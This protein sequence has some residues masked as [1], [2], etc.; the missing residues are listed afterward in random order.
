MNKLEKVVYD[1]VK[2]NPRIKFF[3]RNV[4]QSVLDIMPIP[5][6]YFNGSISIKENYFYGFHDLN[7]FSSSNDKVLANASSLNFKMP[8]DNDEL[9][10]GFFDLVDGKMKTFHQIGNTKAWN[11][12][13]GCRLQWIKNDIIF[14]DFSD[15][16]YISKVVN[17][18]G[19]LIKKF[20]FPIDSLSNNFNFA[21]SFSYERLEFLM[22]GY[23]YRFED[24]SFLSQKRPK[25]TGLFLHNL[26]TLESRLICSL[27]D[28]WKEVKNNND[29]ENYFHFITHTQFSANDR[30][31]SF[32]HRW[33]DPNY[34]LK[35]WS[36][37]HIYDTEKNE[38]ITLPTDFMVSHYIWQGNNI[39]AYCRINNKDNHVFFDINNI[40]KYKI[41]FD[42]KLISDGHQ[43]SVNENLFITDTYPNSRRM[44]KLFL[45]NIENQELKL[46]ASVYHPKKF[47]S[48][49]KNHICVDLHPRASNNNQF[50]CFDTAFTGKRSIAILK[51]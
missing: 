43:T 50:V 26:Q 42:K 33:T 7:P 20:N 8:G 18:N 28:L 5:P 17:T 31:I 16:D 22:P 27:H 36:L 34:T 25:E 40:N 19:S 29:F 30:Y 1:I 11:F 41:L 38:I 10:V 51:F 47:Q 35:R 49:E 13:K 46:L 24:D 3:L 45:C 14:N 44:Q 2:S 21:T 9:S 32:L 39:I 6:N 15:G 4:Y 48:T 12:H 37:L 23:G